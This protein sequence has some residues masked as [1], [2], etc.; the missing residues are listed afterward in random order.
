M[1]TTR[2]IMELVDYEGE[3]MTKCTYEGQRVEDRRWYVI[4]IVHYTAEGQKHGSEVYFAESGGVKQV[5]IWERGVLQGQFP[6]PPSSPSGSASPQCPSSP[7]R[8]EV[9]QSRSAEFQP[10]RRARDE[11]S[12]RLWRLRRQMVI[13]LS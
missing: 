7:Q 12:S 10:E 11:R 4:C 5:N 8:E 6:S 3:A 1:A 2:N 9:R 13:G